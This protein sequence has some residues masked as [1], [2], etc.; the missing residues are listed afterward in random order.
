MEPILAAGL[1]QTRPS[2]GWTR[3][4]MH[5]EQPQWYTKVGEDAYNQKNPAKAQKLLKDAGYAGQPVRWITT[6]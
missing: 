2:T 1:G 3:S 6:K 4:L 5:V